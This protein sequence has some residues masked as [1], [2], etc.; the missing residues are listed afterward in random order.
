MKFLLLFIVFLTASA[1]IARG[2]SAS[3][4]KDNELVSRGKYLVDEVA[5][6][7][8]CHSPRDQ[9]GNMLRDQYLTGAPVPVKA[10]P[11]PEMNW[12]SKAPAIAGLI[13]YTK[14]EGIRL[15]TEGITR[16]GR[17]RIHRCRLFDFPIKTPKLWSI[18]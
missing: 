12:A 5:M 1:A 3:K 15:L 7:V 2:Q 4:T 13:G 16:D 14:E 17:I 8:Q 10:P 6:C 11:Y 9:S 18:I